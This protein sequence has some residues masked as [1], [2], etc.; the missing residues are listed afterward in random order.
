MMCTALGAA[1]IASY[2]AFRKDHV[3]RGIVVA[4]CCAA[5]S[6]FTH[7]N[8]VIWVAFLAV[9]ALQDRRKFRLRDV[10]ALLPYAVFAAGWGLYIAQRP[11]L[12][13][14]QFTANSHPPRRRSTRCKYPSP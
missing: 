10:T 9:L 13:A 12:F 11:G 14:A 7:P 2:L 5:A 8:G 4:N 6:V 3:Y 1:S